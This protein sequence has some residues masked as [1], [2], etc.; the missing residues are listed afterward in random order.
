ML[1]IVCGNRTLIL[2]SLFRLAVQRWW[3]RGEDVQGWAA[4]P[5]SA[6]IAAAAF[7]SFGAGDLQ[8]RAFANPRSPIAIERGLWRLRKNMVPCD[9]ITTL[10]LLR[11][12]LRGSRVVS[13]VE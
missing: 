3:G 12:H 7:E 1:F 6:L 13:E 4:E 2:T 10:H 9:F 8:R 5:L 11:S